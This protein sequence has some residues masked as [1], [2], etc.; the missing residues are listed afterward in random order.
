MFLGAALLGVAAWLGFA[1]RAEAAVDGVTLPPSDPTE[2]SPALVAS[3]PSAYAAIARQAL[4]EMG[5]P[6][7]LPLIM[8]LMQTESSFNPRAVSSAGAMGLMQVMPFVAVDRGYDPNAMFDPEQNIRCGI[9]HLVWT[10]NY[11]MPL[12]K[13]DL[14]SVLSAYNGGVGN[15]SRG[16]FNAGYVSKVI[17]YRDNWAGRVA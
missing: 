10:R 7:D 2:A 11:L 6:F 1:R 16:W 9:A 17:A 13:G 15:V 8:G 14:S 12:G 5:N 3:G 4:G